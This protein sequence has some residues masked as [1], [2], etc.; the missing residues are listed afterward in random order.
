MTRWLL[1]PALN[2]TQE[3][4][5]PV[6]KAPQGSRLSC[7]GVGREVPGVDVTPSLS[8]GGDFGGRCGLL[9]QERLRSLGRPSR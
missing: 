2:R 5:R 6:T 7:L 4:S 9:S 3:P 1:G 8:A